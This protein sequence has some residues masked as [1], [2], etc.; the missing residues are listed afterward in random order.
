MM[1]NMPN[2]QHSPRREYLVVQAA[3]PG[4][5]IENIGILL[6]NSG[7][8][9][10]R[11]LL[12]RDV[13]E[14]AGEEADWFQG[15]DEEISVKSQQLGGQ[16]CLEWMESVLSHGLRISQ[17]HSIVVDSDS[18]MMKRLYKKYTEPKVLP[19]QTHLPL[20]SLEAAA[21]RFGRQMEVEPEGWVEVWPPLALSEDMFV[22]HVKGHSM[23]PIIPDGCLCAIGANRTGSNEGKVVVLERREETGGNCY[24]IQ[25]YRTSKNRDPDV[26][27]NAA[28][29]HERITLNPINPAYHSWDVASAERVSVLGEFLFV[30]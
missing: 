9:Q 19:F 28:W 21:G 8:D 6:L 17:R 27:G 14:F 26:K 13:E 20:F 12:R 15:L 4:K 2:R 24:T 23:E 25:Q 3:L 18:Q 16:H 1:S 7:S 30:V 11:S 10:L 5:Q 29:L 22:T